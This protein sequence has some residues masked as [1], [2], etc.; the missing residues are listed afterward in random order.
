[1]RLI[2]RQAVKSG[3]LENNPIDFV[4]LPKGST[5]RIEKPRTLS[6]AEYSKLLKLFE[7][8]ERLAIQ[9][10]GWLGLGT[11]RSEGFGRKWQDVDL[12]RGVIT[13]R[14]GFVSGPVSQLKTRPPGWRSVSQKRYWTL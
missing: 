4:D 8:R 9:I 3:Y 10:A 5:R 2:F 14:Q 12:K 13:F 6:P 11:R 1:M 7:P